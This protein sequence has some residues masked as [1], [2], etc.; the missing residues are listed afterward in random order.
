M[1]VLLPNSEDFAMHRIF[2]MLRFC[3]GQPRRYGSKKPEKG[4]CP[5]KSSGFPG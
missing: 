3:H 2:V 1:S 4:E 5:E